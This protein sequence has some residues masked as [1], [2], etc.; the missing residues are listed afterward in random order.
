[1]ICSAC[2]KKAQ[3]PKHEADPAGD[4]TL[5]KGWA[6]KF[7]TYQR[8]VYGCSPACLLKAKEN[9]TCLVSID[10]GVHSCA[11][12]AW[13]G[14]TSGPTPSG[15]TLYRGALTTPCGASETPLKVLELLEGW[16]FAGAPVCVEVP[17]KYNT[18]RSTHKDITTLLQVVADIRGAYPPERF[19][20]VTPFAWKGN[21]PKGIQASRILSAISKA[22]HAA[23]TWPKKSQAHN[24]IDAI[25]I[26]LWKSGRLGRGSV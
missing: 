23:V 1:M 26:G 16:G 21:T 15:V 17:V 24:V 3:G 25:G 2:G 10:P 4:Q 6:S 5:P 18:R 12:V 22:E 20:G 13:L 8:S 19:F 11:V 7:Y 14:P 9:A